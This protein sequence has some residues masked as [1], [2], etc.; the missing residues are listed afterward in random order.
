MIH[1]IVLIS[2]VGRTV[3]IGIG[4]CYHFKIIALVIFSGI[5]FVFKLVF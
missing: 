5:Q 2:S 3:V 1:F 4:M